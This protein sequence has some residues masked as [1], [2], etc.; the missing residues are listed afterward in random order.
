M[1]CAETDE[2]CECAFN[3]SLRA[4]GPKE[5]R[6]STERQDECLSEPWEPN[7]C[8][9]D[10]LT[11]VACDQCVE[12]KKTVFCAFKHDDAN[13]HQVKLICR[14]IEGDFGDIADISCTNEKLGLCN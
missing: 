5:C 12:K 8:T 9:F 10:V 3:V 6:F 14:G 13:A 1:N 7:I 11:A 2:A 4:F